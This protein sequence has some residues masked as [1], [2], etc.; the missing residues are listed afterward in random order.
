VPAHPLVAAVET[1]IA[2]ALRGLGEPFLPVLER[3]LAGLTA[4]RGDP[5]PLVQSSRERRAARR[6]LASV[7]GTWDDGDENLVRGFLDRWTPRAQNGRRDAA[8]GLLEAASALA[9]IHARPQTLWFLL[10]EMQSICDGLASRGVV[11]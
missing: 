9:R 10:W 6:F 7:E 5:G 3:R 4:F 11:E 2:P 8:N 1:A